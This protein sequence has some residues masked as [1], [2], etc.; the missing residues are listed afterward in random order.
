MA[1]LFQITASLPS[2]CKRFVQALSESAQYNYLL[3]ALC[4]K[5]K[6]HKAAT[7]THRLKCLIVRNCLFENIFVC[8][9]YNFDMIVTMQSHQSLYHKA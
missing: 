6:I 3:R 9:D 1:C 2:L 5:T 4:A 8:G 7:N